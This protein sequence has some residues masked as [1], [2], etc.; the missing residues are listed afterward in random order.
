MFRDWVDASLLLDNTGD[1]DDELKPFKFMMQEVPKKTKDRKHD[2]AHRVYE[3]N[4]FI[5]L[6]VHSSNT[7]GYIIH[8][9]MKEWE[10]GH[11]HL[12]S[13]DMAKTIISNVIQRKKPKTSNVYLMRSHIRISADEKYNEHIEHLIEIKRDKAKQNYYNRSSK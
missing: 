11:T 9:T 1:L 2:N 7:V 8:N 13:F 10:G 3:K 6:K 12:S 5:I 4:E